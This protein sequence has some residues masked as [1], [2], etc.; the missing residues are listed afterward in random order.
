MRQIRL[1]FLT[2]SVSL[3]PLVFPSFPA[4]PE[5]SCYVAPNSPTVRGSHW[6]KRGANC[7]MV[8]AVGNVA[9]EPGR[10]TQSA[11]KRPSPKK[12]MLA[13]LWPHPSK[14]AVARRKV[15]TVLGKQ[16][17]ALGRSIV[18]KPLG[19][20]GSNK[21]AE[22]DSVSAEGSSAGG[23]ATP[24]GSY[25]A[26]GTN[27]GFVA[28]TAVG[29]VLATESAAAQETTPVEE[30]RHDTGPEKA[31]AEQ[32]SD[33][34]T[35]T[36]LSPAPVL[37]PKEADPKEPITG[38]SDGSELGKR[39]V[40]FVLTWENRVENAERIFTGPTIKA[41]IQNEGSTLASR[42]VSILLGTLAFVF[43]VIL[44]RQSMN[45]FVT[46]RRH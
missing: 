16:I 27:K 7:W 12:V 1:L 13:G 34:A 24:E 4:F 32:D 10:K 2:S 11:Q 35:M 30:P 21:D 36:N 25:S 23:H 6:V 43:V 28:L 44:L 37:I 3:V 14:N 17:A 19:L 42:G 38:T 22:A 8:A 26:M 18:D 9:R 29:P 40:P 39:P 15:G 33:S 5:S 45:L 41:I 46:Q 20:I 31:A